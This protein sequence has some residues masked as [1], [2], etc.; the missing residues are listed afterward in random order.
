MRLR[1]L[2]DVLI[3]EHDPVMKHE[4]LIICP[5]KNSHEKMSPFATIISFGPRCKHQ[6]KVGQK[7]IVPDVNSINH[8][9]PLK[10]QLDGKE[11]RFI[12]EHKINAVLE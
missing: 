10:F 9:T 12:R 3:I 5:E 6:F 8:E 2:N 1:P 11:Y 4:G 7:V